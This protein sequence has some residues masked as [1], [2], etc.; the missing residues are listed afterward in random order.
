MTAKTYEE[1][2]RVCYLAGW[3][4]GAAW[5]AELAE[6]EAREARQEEELAELSE[7]ADDAER[8]LE[9]FNEAWETLAAQLTVEGRTHVAE[10]MREWVKAPEARDFE[11][12][13][14]S[15]LSDKR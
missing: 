12:L 11:R 3:P 2:E 4:L 1:F 5:A 9:Q 7:R 6:V 10:A 15:A 13:L 8:H 14:D